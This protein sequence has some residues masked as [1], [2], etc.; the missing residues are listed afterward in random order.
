MEIIING[1]IVN[2]SDENQE[3]LNE[4]VDRIISENVSGVTG[5]EDFDIANTDTDYVATLNIDHE[6]FNEDEPS[7]IRNVKAEGNEDFS[8]ADMKAAFD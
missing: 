2:V 4:L 6:F 5:N 8:D 1:V 7:D 3:L